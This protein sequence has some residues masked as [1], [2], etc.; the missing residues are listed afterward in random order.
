MLDDV[1]PLRELAADQKHVNLVTPRST[2]R[3]K[4]NYWVGIGSTAGI[5]HLSVWHRCRRGV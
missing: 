5:R 1:T 4:V 2:V 3:T